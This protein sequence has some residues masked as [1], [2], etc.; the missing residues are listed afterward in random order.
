MHRFLQSGG[1]T[2]PGV[3]RADPR[4]RVAAAGGRRARA[5]GQG[6]SGQELCRHREIRMRVLVLGG[7]GQVGR[8]AAGT[9]GAKHEVIVKTRSELDIV[10]A[11]AVGR[12]L[13]D[14]KPDWVVNAAA[15]TAVDLAED[16]PERAVAIN[17]TAVGLVADAAARIGGRLLH[18]STDFIFDG[19]SNRAYLPSDV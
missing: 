10:D 19:T 7:G 14:A 17:E 8:A 15:Y 11:P 13:A 18:L 6:R 9:L 5:V 3:E 2:D 1:R 16:E 12:L 4:H